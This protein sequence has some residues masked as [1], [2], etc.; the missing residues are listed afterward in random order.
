V[1]LAL[2]L[3]GEI[4]TTVEPSM[5]ASA[6]GSGLIDVLSTPSMIGLMEGAA[7]NAVAAQLSDGSVTVGTRVDIRHLAAS[8]LGARIR[9]R[10]ELVEIDGRKLTF[11]VEAFDEQEKIGEG[12]HERAIIDPQR[13]LSRVNQKRSASG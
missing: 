5:L 3:V 13:L 8:P 1:T 12:T 2:G 9:A 4:T 7:V 10:A 6:V 11:R